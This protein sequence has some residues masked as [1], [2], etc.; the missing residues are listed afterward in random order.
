MAGIQRPEAVQTIQEILNK[1]GYDTGTVD[2][3]W[4]RDTSAGFNHF[5]RDVQAHMFPD[6]P[7][8]Q[9]GLYGDNTHEALSAQ[10]ATMYG[11]NLSAEDM[12]R[13]TAAL[14]QMVE[15]VDPNGQPSELGRPLI[16]RLHT[17]TPLAGFESK[18]TPPVIEAAPEAEPEATP[19][20]TPEPEVE[21]APE[22]EA[23]PEVT[24]EPE[25]EAVPEVTP[26]P[27][28]VA[29]IEAVAA[30]LIYAGNMTDEEIVANAVDLTSRAVEAMT[31]RGTFIFD[32][33][34][35]RAQADAMRTLQDLQVSQ[36]PAAIAAST[37]A[38]LG[39]VDAAIAKQQEGVVAGNDRLIDYVREQYPEVPATTE[40]VVAKLRE[41]GVIDD[42]INNKMVGMGAF[43]TAEIR[44]DM[45]RFQQMEGERLAAA[46]INR[47][48]SAEIAAPSAEASPQEVML[49]RIAEIETQQ[50]DLLR[51][52]LP[53][54]N[55]N[56]SA[57]LVQARIE[58]MRDPTKFATF[59][60]HL[61]EEGNLEG[62]QK[63]DDFQALEQ[64]RVEL[65]GGYDQ[66]AEEPANDSAPLSV[67]QRIS[68]A[69]DAAAAVP[70]DPALQEALQNYVARQNVPG[71]GP[72]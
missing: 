23:V 46:N 71:A 41:P 45:Q 35:V 26:E 28:S 57:T 58:N 8:E 4:G 2:G 72:Q 5:V 54:D 68:Q 31:P 19:D 55:P 40:G 3:M 18:I 6:Q 62:I 48:M 39:Q 17:P 22:A 47:V 1:A 32:S 64:T 61:V 50:E 53:H 29:P 52:V 70:A 33:D 11:A 7:G 12:A 60:A 9:D 49:D 69:F 66:A 43:G 27:E 16:N 42:F 51:Q 44:T 63:L 67:D 13:L 10:I 56:P 14:G 24:P 30:P 65:I 20:V 36:D 21:T 37:T 25:A 59:R 34:A 15:R 38:I